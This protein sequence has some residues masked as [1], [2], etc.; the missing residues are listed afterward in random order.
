MEFCRAEARVCNGKFRQDF[1]I[2]QS[3]SL[4]SPKQRQDR[5][6]LR[7]QT[8]MNS[9]SCRALL[10]SAPKASG[11]VRSG[12]Q[13]HSRRLATAVDTRQKVCYSQEAMRKRA[14]TST[15]DPAEF[16][17]VTTLPNGVRV[18]TEA[19]PGPFSGIGVYVDAGS[20]YEDEELRGV[21]HII[22]R[23]AFKVMELCSKCISVQH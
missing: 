3:Q 7:L 9:P 14:L 17:Q 1:M 15:K 4:N 13:Q 18:A 11:L 22:D 10:R 16:D 21:S 2:N 20:R 8:V 6:L 12:I 19:L 23:L 5:R